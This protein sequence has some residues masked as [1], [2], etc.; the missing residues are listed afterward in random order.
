MRISITIGIVYTNRS[1]TKNAREKNS[2]RIRHSG[3]GAVTLA[4]LNLFVNL[5]ERVLSK[6]LTTTKTAMLKLWNAEKDGNAHQ[7]CEMKNYEKFFLHRLQM[8]RNNDVD[9][10]YDL[11][12]ELHLKWFSWFNFSLLSGSWIVLRFSSVV[13]V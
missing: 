2:H 9:T 5:I 11:S 6:S 4:S 10:R 12:K 3:N 8:R 1:C 13:N 7:R